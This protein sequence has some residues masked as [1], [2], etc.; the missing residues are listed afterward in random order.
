[1]RNVFRCT[2]IFEIWFKRLFEG[3]E[4]EKISEIKQN[5]VDFQDLKECFCKGFEIFNIT[6]SYD[7]VK[8]MQVFW[9]FF[10]YLTVSC[11]C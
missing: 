11:M 10:N 5:N 3:R 1:M 7:I 4:V 8:I 6:Y 2:K 9:F